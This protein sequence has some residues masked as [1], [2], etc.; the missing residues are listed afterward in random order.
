MLLL[1]LQNIILSV[2]VYA[3]E[4]N[5]FGFAL[6]RRGS[7]TP[8]FLLCRFPF[9]KSCLSSFL[10]LCVRGKHFVHRIKSESKVKIAQC[11]PHAGIPPQSFPV[12]PSPFR[13]PP[14]SKKRA[15]L[16]SRGPIADPSSSTSGEAPLPS[17]A[18]E[19]RHFA[20]ARAS[21]HMP[22]WGA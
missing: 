11:P 3:S 19:R 15:Q 4:F 5:L 18:M 1:S 9:L 16:C 21:A 17:E 14:T 10:S 13:V 7:L 22:I 6:L 12:A 20:P 8:T 2:L